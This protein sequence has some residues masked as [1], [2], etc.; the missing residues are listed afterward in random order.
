MIPCSDAKRSDWL[1]YWSNATGN[2]VSPREPDDD[3]D[4]VDEDQEDDDRNEERDPAV[5]REPDE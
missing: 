4:D 2:M 1:N 5:I 3:D